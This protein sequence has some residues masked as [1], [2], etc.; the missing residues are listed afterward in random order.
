MIGCTPYSYDEEPIKPADPDEYEEWLAEY[1]DYQ[2][3]E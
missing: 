3:G 1:G 2:Q